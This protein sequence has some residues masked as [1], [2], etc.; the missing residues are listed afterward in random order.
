MFCAANKL[1]HLGQHPDPTS[2]AFWQQWRESGGQATLFLGPSMHRL[3]AGQQLYDEF[4]LNSI[5]MCIL[6]PHEGVW[7]SYCSED[8]CPEL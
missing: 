1:R 7:G 4:V 6:S 8:C 2:T 5:A 3:C